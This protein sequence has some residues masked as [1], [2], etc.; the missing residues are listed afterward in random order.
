[1]NIQELEQKAKWIRS[2]C[3]K[4][5][6]SAKEGHLGSALSC[7]DILVA[8]YD[9]FDFRPTIESH[10]MGGSQTIVNPNRDRLYFSKGHAASALYATMKEFGHIPDNMDTYAKPDSSLTPHPDKNL[11][12]ELEMSSGSL[13]HGLG[14]ACGAALALKLSGSKAKCV[15]LMGDGECNEGSVWEAAQFAAA[16]KL[17]NLIVVIDYNGIQ[18][19]GRTD[20]I[21]GDTSLVSKFR[22][23][24]WAA[25]DIFGHS[26]SVHDLGLLTD[27]RCIA[28]DKPLAFIAETTAG[29]GVSFM[30]DDSRTCLWHYRVPSEDEVKRALEE[31]N[32]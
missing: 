6:Y 16:H 5:S 26:F 12:P 17:D 15:V 2:Q 10:D 7:V 1:M 8:L 25:N 30:E 29:A 14:V 9:Y 32:A 4:M 24:G 23:F 20:L 13:G 22:A 31:L 3:I 18:S 27:L 19:I 11:L 28:K 21:S